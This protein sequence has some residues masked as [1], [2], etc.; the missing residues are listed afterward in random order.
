[1]EVLDIAPDDDYGTRGSSVPLTMLYHSPAQMGNDVE[2]LTR[3]FADHLD[4]V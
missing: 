2:F 1:M 4:W 3:D